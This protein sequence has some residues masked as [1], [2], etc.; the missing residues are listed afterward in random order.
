[1]PLLDIL[2]GEHSDNCLFAPVISR[3]LKYKLPVK[4][5]FVYQ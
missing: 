1:M 3:S 5:P 2:R 4:I